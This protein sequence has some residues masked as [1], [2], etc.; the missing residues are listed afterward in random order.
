MLMT[1][2][3]IIFDLDNTLYPRD[4]GLM[5]EIGRRIQ[6]WLCK[7]LGLT[8]EE[9]I[10][11]RRDYLR[12]YGTT[13]GGLMAEQ[14]TDVHDYLAFVHE[15]P[16]EEYLEPNRALDAMLASIPLRKVI[17]TNATSE[18]AWRVL[19]A[20]KVADHFEQVI[21]IE[22]MDLRNKFNSGAYGRL[23]GLLGASGLECI[24]VEDSAH[25]LRPAKE[26]GLTTI[27]LDAG[28]STEGSTV[29]SAEPRV[30]T[31]D[32]FVDFAVG[33][34]LDVGRVVDALLDGEDYGNSICEIV[35]RWR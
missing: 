2:Q 26:L 21:G 30:E 9:A 19:Q 17:Y 32:E 6:V 8:W 14:G 29:S 10:D 16:V 35:A 33:S 3:F 4:S 18:H 7:N 13:M 25:N 27:L 20:L 12:R 5:Q 1:F 15:V 22:E 31:P 34:V 23:L 11:A 28:G 24:M